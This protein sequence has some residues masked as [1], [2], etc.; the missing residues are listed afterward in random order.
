MS[1]S[2]YKM[3]QEHV[4]KGGFYSAL[5]VYAF[6]CAQSS[7]TLLTWSAIVGVLM[8]ICFF[9]EITLLIQRRHLPPGRYGLPLM[10]EVPWFVIG[11]KMNFGAFTAE[12]KKKWGSIF[13]VSIPFTATI[14]SE[15][16]DLHWLFQME[17]KGFVE[18]AWPSSV[19]AILG[20]GAIANVFGEQHR[21]I[22]SFFQ[23][24]FSPAFVENYLV[25]VDVT[26][27]EQL[28]EWSA[29]SSSSTLSSDVFK[30]FAL[31]LFFA[32]SFGKVD[33]QMLITFHDN[34]KTWLGGFISLTGTVRVPGSPFDQAMAARDRIL[35]TIDQVIDQFE[36]ENPEGSDRAQNTVIGRCVYASGEEGL[37]FDRS[38]LKDIL[39]NLIFAGH[40]T[41]TGAMGSV[42]YHL[43]HH[44]EAR[45]AL[46]EEIN[47]FFSK[48]TSLDMEK[49]K[50]APILNAII[51]ETLRVDPPVLA[52]PRSTR[53]DLVY[54]NFRFPKDSS[55]F[56]NIY[57]A[58]TD[59]NEYK[60]RPLEFDFRRFLPQDHKLYDPT[61]W[62]HK[63][64]RDI[65]DP[66]QGR[67]NYPI[68]GGGS[69]SCLG[70]HFALL[71]LRVFLVRL[72]QNYELSVVKETK[73][74]L[75]I[76]TWNVEFQLTKKTT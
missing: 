56:Y 23:P 9:Q 27:Q 52:G 59:P 44:A 32:A 49:L 54:K 10:G 68:F 12:R 39:L 67:A 20:P 72:F 60:Y 17:R 22:R 75:P 7:G 29:L 18:A 64:A 11:N 33:E 1:V 45:A 73:V 15:Q 36:K 53:Q 74:W 24:W 16:D 3:A 71:E 43:A 2:Y 55:I 41:T 66:A 19:A 37:C 42:I 65:V 30:L 76:C 47:N 35:T 50:S 6:S 70:K 34:F 21:R 61:I 57:L 5:C 26:V 13:H 8:A 25:V 63:E 40:D 28:N 14:V 62:N 38:Q 31:R 58:A 4:W 48:S 46:E 69:R 51:W